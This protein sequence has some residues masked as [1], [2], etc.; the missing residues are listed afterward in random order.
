MIMQGM[1]QI[2]EAY[3]ISFRGEINQKN[4]EE[5]ENEMKQ[6]KTGISAEKQEQWILQGKYVILAVLVGIC[7][8]I[9]DTIFGRG[10]LTISDFREQYYRYLLPI[11]PVAGLAIVWMYQRFSSLS[12]K[13]M[14]LVF[15]VGQK[16]REEIPLAL[17]P[18]VMIGTWITH[19]FGGSAGREG[20]AVQIGAT[21]SHETG[22]R[23][24]IKETKP[25]M[26]IA[27]MAAGFG[28]LFQTPLA[29]VF[30]AME[31]GVSGYVE[32]DALLPALI[33]SYTASTTSH[34]LGLEKF[35]VD[36]QEIWQIGNIKNVVILVILGLAFGLTGRCFSVLLQKTKK[37]AGDKISNPL[38]RIGCLAIP[39]AIVLMA[40]HSA[41]YSGLGTNLITASFTG[42]TIYRYD[43]ILKLL[44]TIA[45][46]AIG[47]QGG[48]VTPLFSIGASLGVVLGS[49]FGISPVIC[50]SLGYAAVFG[51]A[52]NTVIAPILTGLE[53]FGSQNA[54]PLVVV[55]LLAYMVNGNHSIY[56]AQVKAL[57]SFEEK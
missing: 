34:L 30:F 21:L 49:V 27:G 41:R 4:M 47:F 11:L 43:W 14:T 22:R 25:V 46:L 6:K 5:R 40:L 52:T 19:L 20:V 7:V 2:R 13:G 1:S 53:V 39:L 57:C 16:K 17:V 36:V 24:H 8:G 32:Y 15:E 28:G 44:L 50:A 45:T 3:F 37:L 38:V 23:L 56:G 51:S 54:I 48:E 26:L 33:A 35:A 9:V 18:L 55:C 31:V 29:A 12:L 10:L 42:D